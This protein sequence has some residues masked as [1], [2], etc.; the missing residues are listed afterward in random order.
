LLQRPGKSGGTNTWSLKAFFI[1]LSF[2][3]KIEMTD[4]YEYRY[5]RLPDVLAFLDRESGDHPPDSYLAND[6]G[7]K[8]K[9]D[10][11]RALAEGF[12]WKETLGGKFVIFERKVPLSLPATG[13][14]LCSGEK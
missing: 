4:R 3:Q 1:S 10:F 2:E 13:T 5:F 6:L 12:R 8:N 11:D 9:T 14:P 7:C